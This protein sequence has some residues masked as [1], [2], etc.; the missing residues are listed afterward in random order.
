MKKLSVLPSLVFSTIC[1]LSLM[2][3]V[4][5]GADVDSDGD[6][7]NNYREE[8]DGTNP[9][10]AASFN[11]LSKGL[12][13]Y[14]PLDGTAND[15]SGNGHN[16][17]VH[18]ATA[19]P[20]RF[21]NLSEALSFDGLTSYVNV[22]QSDFLHFGNQDFAIFAWVRCTGGY[23]PTILNNGNSYAPSTVGL[24]F[25]LDFPQQG[26]LT[27]VYGSDWWG[28]GAVP[29]Q[30][31]IHVGAT[32]QGGI[33][34]LWIN[35]T[36]AASRPALSAIGASPWPLLI[37]TATLTD[38]EF[39]EGQIDDIRVYSRALLPGE[40]KQ[41]YKTE[42]GSLDSD[43]DG[44]ND[45]RELEDG[46]NPNDATSFNPLSV[47]LVAYYPFNGDIADDSGFGRSGTISGSGITSSLDRFFSTGGALS[48]SGSASDRAVV[49][50]T[51]FNVNTNF[52]ISFWCYGD[53]SGNGSYAATGTGVDR[54]DNIICT[55]LEFSGGLNIR[56]VSFQ[57]PVWQVFAANLPQDGPPW[58]GF[59][60]PEYVSRWGH[61]AYVRSGST[62][63]TYFNGTLVSQGDLLRPI[64]D[65]G[66]LRIGAHTFG[67]N[68]DG[69]YNMVGSI[70]DMRIYQRSLS[71]AD[72]QSLFYSEA[73]SESQKSF[74]ISSPYVIG[75]YS[76]ADYD[77]NRTNGQTD[78]TTNPSAF[79]L[80]TQSEYD[81]FGALQFSNGVSSVISNPAVFNL[82]TEAEFNSNR[83]AGQSD[84]MNSP[85][86]YGLYTSNSIMDLRMGGLMIQR[87]GTN[88]VVSF[89][90]QTTTD[91]TQPFTN[92]G[93]PIT[94]TIP[95]PGN[96]GFIRINAKP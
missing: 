7:V 93:T 14:Y 17:T 65:M 62:W 29:R 39:F 50:P 89:Q 48:L 96:K 11:S 12:V 45:Y 21:G 78:V 34:R 32:R 95:M 74:L 19:A 85:T 28:G 3:Y 42:V 23:Y 81:G 49:E 15:E 6:G 25:S 20:N 57:N 83:T 73:F 43:G 92:N 54:V 26:N 38:P 30:K 87:Q 67:A 88:A 27:L 18:N 2:T 86:S 36:E 13:A 66:S 24:E 9:N 77:L 84:V 52:T 40:V 53:P 1:A 22:P 33:D 91:L 51:P 70:D 94:N 59:N 41:L 16:G 37:G 82:F 90:P 35:G 47:G 4:A 44:A 76:Q 10:N 72:I 5:D 46:T 60:T 79:N 75:H 55:G 64:T 56:Y 8:K 58:G 63:Q 69:G 80:F 61:I 68:E 71:S 31:W